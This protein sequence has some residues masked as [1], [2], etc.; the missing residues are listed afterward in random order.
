MSMQIFVKTLTGNTITLD[1][2]SSDT[3]NTVRQNIQDKEGIFPDQ[4]RLMF[5]GK[6]LEDGR[7]LTDYNIQKESTLHLVLRL[8]GGSDDDDDDDDDDDAPAEAAAPAEDKPAESTPEGEGK[9]GEKEGPEPLFKD[10]TDKQEMVMMYAGMVLADCKAE[11]TEDSINKVLSA[12]KIDFV[13]PYWPKMFAEILKGKD[14]AKL[15]EDAAG[16]PGAGGGGGAAAAGGEGG[17]EVKKEE[18]KEEEEDDDVGF[19]SDD[20][21]D[22]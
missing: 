12:A 6:Q 3:I 8:R 18:K 19:D 2:D 9:E 21:D 11:I 22:E 4:M 17:A 14:V 16:S 20:D 13:A 15:I 1:V 7:T 5:A 10:D